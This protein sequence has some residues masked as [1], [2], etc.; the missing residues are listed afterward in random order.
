[1]ENLRV[2]DLLEP[3]R[4][5]WNWGLIGGLLYVQDKAE[6]M[7]IAIRNLE[8]GDKLI[9]KFNNQGNYMVKWAYRY[10]METL[11]DNGNTKYR[12]SG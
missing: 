8:G 7:K 10:A 1:M 9:W 11:I 12:M 4:V 3:N 2:A 5:N 6:I